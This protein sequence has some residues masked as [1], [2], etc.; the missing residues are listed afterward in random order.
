MD[1]KV[2]LF[3]AF[4]Y[5]VYGVHLWHTYKKGQFKRCVVAYNDIFRK[6][7][8]YQRGASIS[9]ATALLSVDTFNVVRRR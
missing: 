1:V 9:A 7:F 4:C 6:L 2:R 5:S 3:K 8:I